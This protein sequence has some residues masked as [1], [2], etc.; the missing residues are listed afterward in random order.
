MSGAASVIKNIPSWAQVTF[1]ASLCMFNGI[2][3]QESVFR[4]AAFDLSH[5]VKNRFV[6]SFNFTEAI[7][8]KLHFD[9]F[10][11][12]LFCFRPNL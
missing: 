3:A 4:V 1:S 9:V 2:Y 10:H 6:I 11:I 12:I 8:A 5:L 7:A